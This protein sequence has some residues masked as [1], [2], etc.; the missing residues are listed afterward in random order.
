MFSKASKTAAA[1]I[2]SAGLALSGVSTGFATEATPEPTATTQATPAPLKLTK[3][4]RAALKSYRDARASFVEAQALF[5][6]KKTEYKEAKT[7]YKLALASYDASVKEWETANA[8]QIAAIAAVRGAFSNA[9]KDARKDFVAARK[10][11][12]G[13]KAKND[14]FAAYTMALAAAKAT[15]D[16]NLAAIGPI[17]ERPVKPVKVEKPELVPPVKP[18]KQTPAP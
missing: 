7:S 11:A 13:A 1:L 16:A 9:T 4:E 17:P 5:I 12:V 3:A 2:L 6:K 8:A 14:A 15:M 10:A 18:V